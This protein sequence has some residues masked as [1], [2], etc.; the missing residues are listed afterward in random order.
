MR[1]TVVVLVAVLSGII[2]V[3]SATEVECSDPGLP[4]GGTR[5]G[6]SRF[7]PGSKL[8]FDCPVGYDRV[9]SPVSV[10]QDSG[11]WSLPV[12][13]CIPDCPRIAAPV[14]G[15]VSVR[16]A[17][18]RK[19]GSVARFTCDPGYSLV[20]AVVITCNNG[21]WN[22]PVPYCF[23]DCMAVEAPS[24]AGVRGG[25]GHGDVIYFRCLEGFQLIGKS[26]ITCQ[27]GA[28]SDE[29]PRCEGNSMN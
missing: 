18:R 10:C 25:T 8:S 26:M 7:T 14:N 28:W 20:G 22:R 16:D 23:A 17:A 4:D 3:A 5:R 11:E 12:P 27:D 21:Q 2:S 9:G 19:Y 6:P 13:R 24:N 15:A 1:G 29:Y